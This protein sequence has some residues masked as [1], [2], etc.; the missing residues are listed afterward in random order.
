[1]PVNARVRRVS[2]PSASQRAY[3]YGQLGVYL[4][5]GTAL[6]QA[7]ESLSMLAS[8]TT[9]RFAAAVLEGTRQGLSLADACAAATRHFPEFEY[10][11]LRAGEISGRLPVSCRN[12]EKTILHWKQF[13]GSILLGCLYPIALIHLSILLIPLPA[14]VLSGDFGAYGRTVLLWLI[15][16]HGGFWA[17]FYFIRALNRIP[18][19]SAIFEGL[20]RLTPVLGK[21]WWALAVS[22]FTEAYD[23]LLNAGVQVAD[24]LD[25]ASQAAHS[26]SM[27]AKVE[28]I[29]P[30]VRSGQP[31]G[32]Q[33]RALRVLGAPWDDLWVTGEQSGQQEQML[34]RIID[35]NGIRIESGFKTLRWLVPAALYGLT[36]LVF[37]GWIAF[38]F[39]AFMKGYV[40]Q[41]NDAM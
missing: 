17:L 9:R 19:F 34:R 33:F 24:A 38:R 23:G 29:L 27:R 32:V 31:I 13:Q 7:L 30:L 39:Y 3:F 14:A 26:H 40:G 10:A 20:I 4:E 36:V 2:L 5:A 25:I 22:R 11:L 37:G 21:T 15:G 35:E 6:Q 1:M 28:R 12:I 8:A 41:I 16:L 18:A